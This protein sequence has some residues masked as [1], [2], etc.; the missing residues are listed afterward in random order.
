MKKIITIAAILVLVSTSCRKQADYNPY[1]GEN[2][3]LAYSTYTE[4]FDY[5]WKVLSTGY[6]FWDVDTT[7]WDA[8]YTRYYPKFQELDE[9]YRQQGYVPTAE[10]QSLYTGLVG[11]MCDHH[12]TFRVRNLHP[13]PDDQFLRTH[14]R[15]PPATTITNRPVTKT[16]ESK[17]FCKPL[18]INI[19]L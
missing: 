14:W 4:Q 18:R 12:M 9:K 17:F 6:V 16:K 5:L 3:Q 10:L 7:D 13:A 1:I 15:F 2:G 8:A 11:G 19:L